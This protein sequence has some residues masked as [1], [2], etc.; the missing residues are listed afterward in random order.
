MIG[1]G[2]HD[3]FDENHTWLYKKNENWFIKR[4]AT[5]DLRTM[6]HADMVVVLEEDGCGRV[7]KDRSSANISVKYPDEM[8]MI[9]LSAETI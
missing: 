8:M 5:A 4:S 1:R 9:M 3:L 7:I 2:N 6:S